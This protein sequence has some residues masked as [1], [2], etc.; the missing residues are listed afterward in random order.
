MDSGAS[1]H[2]THVL[3]DFAE[4]RPYDGPMLSTANKD[5]PLQIKGEGIVFLTHIVTSKSGIKKKV[6][7]RF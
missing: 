4:F 2:F 7:T 5:A 6:I 3:S 1:K